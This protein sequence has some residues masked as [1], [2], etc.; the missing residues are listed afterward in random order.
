MRVISLNVG[1]VR[2]ILWEGREVR[3]GFQKRPVHGKVALRGVNLEGDDQADRTVH[4]GTGK[5]IYVYP[6]EH[7]PYW[8]KELERRSLDWGAFGENLTT[9]GWLESTAHLGD[10]VR[11]GTAT[12]EITQPRRPCYKLNAIF[13]RPD[14]V[15]RFHRSGRSGFYLGPVSEGEMGEGDPIE[16]LSRKADAPSISDILEAERKDDPTT[17]T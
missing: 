1:E 10:V 7:Y 6:S 11:I 3:T 15:E 16:L 12:L 8:R 13:A 14:M 4:G 5:T 17:R 9:S 2:T